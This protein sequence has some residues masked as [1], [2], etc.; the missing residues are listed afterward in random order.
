MNIVQR[1][2]FNKYNLNSNKSIC[3][4]FDIKYFFDFTNEQYSPLSQLLDDNK[5]Q[6]EMK[7]LNYKMQNLLIE[8]LP[9]SDP[10]NKTFKK[11]SR[12]V[13]TKVLKTKFKFLTINL[14]SWILYVI[15]IICA[16]FQIWGIFDMYTNQEILISLYLTPSIILSILIV[17]SILKCY[18]LGFDNMGINQ[19]MN[20]NIYWNNFIVYLCSI[21][22]LIKHTEIQ[23]LIFF[24]CFMCS[25]WFTNFLTKIFNN[26]KQE[27]L[28]KFTRQFMLLEVLNKSNLDVKEYVLRR[29]D[30]LQEFIFTFKL[31]STRIRKDANTKEYMD[32]QKWQIMFSNIL[33]EL[34]LLEKIIYGEQLFY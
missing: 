34:G 31:R 10:K 23:H 5:Y 7:I 11:T 16:A 9:K 27:K 21:I 2:E 1:Q 18:Y 28:N 15:W 13:K 33:N 6:T 14:I 17:C 22:G 3:V 26:N 19:V 24:I 30:L 4:N 8:E 25:T 20:F 12:K 29:Y 32:N